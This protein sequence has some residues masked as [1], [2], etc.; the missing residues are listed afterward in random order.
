MSAVSQ[1]FDLAVQHHQSGRLAQAE[2]LYRQILAVQ[3]AHADSLHMLGV[4]A[5]Q[6]GRADAAAEF[7]RQAI[8]L[9][10]NNPM[11]HCNLGLVC[12]MT[13]SREEAIACYERALRLKP[14]YAE[15]HNNL[16][17]S[18]VELGRL[19]DA[20]EAFRRALQF[21]TD[22]LDAFI[23]LGNAL[24]DRGQMDEAIAA[25]CRALAL[26]P[27][28]VAAHYNFGNA[29]RYLGRLDEAIARFHYA[30]QFS[31]GDVMIL[32][33]IILTLHYKPG[34]VSSMIAEAQRSWNRQCSDRLKPFIQPH[35]NDRSPER[36]LRVAYVSPDFR[37]HVVARNLLPL[38]R[39][40]EHENFEIFCYSGAVQTDSTTKEFQRHSDHWRSVVGMSDEAMAAAVRGEAIDIFVDLSQHTPGNRLPVFARQPAPVQVSFAGY[41]EG[42]GVEGI[43]YRISDRWL[44]GK[45]KMQVSGYRSQ[46]GENAAAGYPE[47]CDLRPASC[48]YLLDS[49]WCYDPCGID[50]AVNA[51]PA[52]ENGFVT[53]GSLNSFIKVNESVLKLWARVLEKVPNSRLLLLADPGSQREW[54]SRLLG[55]GGVDPQRIEFVPRLSRV[56]YFE[57]YHRIDIVLDPFPYGG[58]TTSL[59]ALWMGVPVVSLAGQ[60]AASRAGLSQTA[61][62]G[63]D[64]LVAFSEDEYVAN[65]DA[66]GHDLPRLAELRRTLRSRMEG[67]ALMDAPRFARQIEAAYRA[68]WRRWSAGE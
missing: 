61:N 38:F 34:D 8:K 41:P 36:R 35:R 28:S 50:L 15:A 40:H 27:D 60:R 33:T 65:A 52:V 3:P 12:R 1:F 5:Q 26:K 19:D 13:G 31:P 14:D 29:L 68:M 54:V 46:D 7:I 49:F 10:P 47:S 32:S 58:H 25:Y 39:N 44:E 63:L 24:K 53:F 17:I 6:T 48:V 9:A 37:E 59:D 56:A 57:S 67:S 42:T 21:K 2:L 22:Y 66:L 43:E 55:E 64:G 20:V 4:I 62:L 30:L 23:N 51:L 11:A 45:G 16:G 18:L